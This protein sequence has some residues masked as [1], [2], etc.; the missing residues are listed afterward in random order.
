M[1]ADLNVIWTDDIGPFR[2]RKV[3]IFNGAHTMARIFMVRIQL[4][5]EIWII[6]M[7][8]CVNKTAELLA[9]EAKKRFVSKTDNILSFYHP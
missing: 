2:A 7:V 8:G 4:M 9:N 1:K 3:R 6:N 5:N